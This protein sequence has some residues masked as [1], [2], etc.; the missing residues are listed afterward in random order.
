MALQ[1]AYFGLACFSVCMFFGVLGKLADAVVFYLKNP[2][3]TCHAISL[4]TVTPDANREMS[5][6]VNLPLKK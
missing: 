2:R 4:D 1:W 3:S 5:V 6:V